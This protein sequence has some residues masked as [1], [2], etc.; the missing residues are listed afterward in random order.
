MKYEM[1]IYPPTDRET[2]DYHFHADSPF[3]ACSIGDSICLP[4]T[5]RAVIIE[6]L[7]HVII[8]AKD[9]GAPDTHKLCVYTRA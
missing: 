1:E 6:G 2:C 7:L 3:L 4:S 8:G 5:G 9:G